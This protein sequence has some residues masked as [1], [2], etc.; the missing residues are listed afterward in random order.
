MFHDWPRGSKTDA[1]SGFR[2][3]KDLAL[4][5]APARVGPLHLEEQWMSRPLGNC[6]T[7]YSAGQD[8]KSTPRSSGTV[9][10]GTTSTRFIS[11]AFGKHL[12]VQV[13]IG[14]CQLVIPQLLPAVARG[15]VRRLRPEPPSSM[16]GS[17]HR[18]RSTRARI[19]FK[20]NLRC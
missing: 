13:E 12:L 7:C 4:K 17:V 8:G 3:D 15:P 18:R 20:G 16:A 10:P 9:G 6:G 5:L 14:C 19:K 1:A 11:A 2:M